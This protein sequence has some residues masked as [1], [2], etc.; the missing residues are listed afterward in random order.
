MTVGRLTS[1]RSAI[2]EREIG[3][4]RRMIS[5]IA[6]R[7]ISRMAEVVIVI[8]YAIKVKGALVRTYLHYV[9][10]IFTV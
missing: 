10:L 6:A 3:L 9:I 5:R 7:F 4:S 8:G 2:A 1:S